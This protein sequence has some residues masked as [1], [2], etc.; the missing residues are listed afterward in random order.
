MWEVFLSPLHRWANW[1]LAN[2][3][4]LLWHQLVMRWSQNRVWVCVGHSSSALIP[5]KWKLF[6]MHTCCLHKGLPIYW[7]LNTHIWGIPSVICLVISFRL[8]VLNLGAVGPYRSTDWFQ[9]IMGP[10]K[11]D[12]KFGAE[13]HTWI[14]R[15]GSIISTRFP[16]VVWDS[17]NRLRTTAVRSKVR[18]VFSSPTG[19]CFKCPITLTKVSDTFGR[20]KISCQ[21]LHRKQGQ[22]H[23]FVKSLQRG[24]F[25]TLTKFHLCL[26]WI[27]K[28]F[29]STC[30]IC[31]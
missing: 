26:S 16:E 27:V 11:L 1:G 5:E 30:S 7:L 6:S 29:P 8:E 14:W 10:L 22:N 3:I 12:V 28:H 19:K 21:I 31:L 24:Y 9:E 23:S 2:L 13:L 4:I 15:K 17:K 18:F 20:N 25:K